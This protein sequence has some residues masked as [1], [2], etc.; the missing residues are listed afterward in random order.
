MGHYNFSSRKFVDFQLSQLSAQVLLRVLDYGL[1]YNTWNL[2]P[3]L[4]FK[5]PEDPS[6][7]RLEVWERARHPD[8][9]ALNRMSKC[10]V[11]MQTVVV[12][13]DVQSAAGPF[14][15]L[16]D[17]RAQIV[18]IAEEG[19]IE[20]FLDFADKC[21]RKNPDARK[22]DFGKESNASLESRLKPI[23]TK[24]FDNQEVLPTI[25]PA[26]TFRLCT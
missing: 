3:L 6:E 1:S 15:L 22:E 24:Q 21:E 2:P 26:I 5:P 7:K 11:V 9:E 14:G 13:S 25:R 23:M 19:K 16:G 12:H 18:D 8:L 10:Q 20:A 17:A 4:H